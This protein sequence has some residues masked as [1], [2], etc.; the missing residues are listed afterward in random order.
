[1]RPGFSGRKVVC[2]SCGRKTSRVYRGLCHCAEDDR[3][4]ECGFGYGL[5]PCGGAMAVPPDIQ[6]A[7]RRARAKADLAM[8]DGK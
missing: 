6:G 1:M 2:V 4:C 8:F 7:E 5:C 3:R